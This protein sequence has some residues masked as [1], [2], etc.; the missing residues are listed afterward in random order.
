MKNA[1]MVFKDKKKENVVF[2]NK[3]CVRPIRKVLLNK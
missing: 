1:L 2:D 3:I